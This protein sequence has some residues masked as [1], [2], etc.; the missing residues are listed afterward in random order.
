MFPALQNNN[1][2]NPVDVNG[3]ECTLKWTGSNYSDTT[4]TWTIKRNVSG[5]D[6]V[7][8]RPTIIRTAYDRLYNNPYLMIIFIGQNKGYDDDL[9]VLVR[10]HRSIIEHANAKHVIVLGLS[11]GDAVSRK[12][13]EERMKKEFG[14]YFISLREYLAHPIYDTDGSTIVSCY[15]IDDQG[16][17]AD[18]A[19]SYGGNTYNSLEEIAK[20]KVP[21]QILMDGL[22]FSSGTRT[23]I[24]NLIYKRCKELNIF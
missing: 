20:G 18:T 10:Q 9:D 17:T 4:G 16:L 19:Y 22:H 8:N 2:L 13:Y 24:G 11:S 14:R 23:V 1:N 6:I 7:I 3:V 15:G 5:D 12:P 21:H